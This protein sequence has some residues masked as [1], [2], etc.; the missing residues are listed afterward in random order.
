MHHDDNS[1]IVKIIVSILSIL[2]MSSR[3]SVQKLGQ[4]AARNDLLILQTSLRI[5][6]APGYGSVQYTYEARAET[7]KLAPDNRKYLTRHD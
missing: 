7:R 6:Q 3:D 4:N 5:F 1:L 2:L